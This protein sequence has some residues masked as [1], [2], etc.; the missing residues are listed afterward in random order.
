[1]H[2]VH[3][4][5]SDAESHDVELTHRGLFSSAALVKPLPL[6]CGG[7]D[8]AVLPAPSVRL[9]RDR[10]LPVLEAHTGPRLV[11]PQAVGH[12][13]VDAQ[14]DVLLGAEALAHVAVELLV[15]VRC[16]GGAEAASLGRAVIAGCVESLLRWISQ[17][18]L[19]NDLSASQT[20]WKGG[21]EGGA[22]GSILARL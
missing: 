6:G 3:H 10:R 17:E 12:H 11:H 13:V 18:T 9:Q 14:P 19:A 15:L 2:C 20:N 4:L 1:M 22:R 21:Y 7:E 5:R 16:Q 8:G